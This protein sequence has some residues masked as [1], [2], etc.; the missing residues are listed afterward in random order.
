M[1]LL[2]IMCARSVS[3]SSELRSYGDDLEAWPLAR[4]EL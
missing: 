4:C 1:W 2:P 3:K